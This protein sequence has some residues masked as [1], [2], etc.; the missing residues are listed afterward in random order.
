MHLIKTGN[1]FESKM[2]T[3]V[4]P[5][6]CVGVMGAGLALEFKRKYPDM[7]TFYQNACIHKPVPPLLD[8]GNPVLYVSH[9]ENTR[10]VLFPTKNHWK[11][12][13]KIEYIEKGLDAFVFKYREWGITSVAFPALGCG[14]GGLEWNQVRS[15]MV[16]KLRALP[17]P[18]EIYRPKPSRVM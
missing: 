18:I 17:I 6:N 1:I 11:D 3:L 13:S 9:D 2:Q 8:T 15:L 7:F 4:N 10:I 14:Y 5:V 16:E 12:P